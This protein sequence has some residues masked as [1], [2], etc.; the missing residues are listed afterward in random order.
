[1]KKNLSSAIFIFLTIL[2]YNSPGIIPQLEARSQEGLKNNNKY[3]PA[4]NY[5]VKKAASKIKID[6]ILN[7]EAW[8]Y[9]EKIKILYE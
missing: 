6:G 5:V 3:P 7:E 2:V 4:K 8:K 1:M 9:P